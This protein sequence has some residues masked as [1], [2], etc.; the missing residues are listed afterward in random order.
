MGVALFS[1]CVNL[2]ILTIIP[3]YMMQ[4]YDRVLITSSID[5]LLTLSAMV[6]VGLATF[7]LL[8]AVRNRILA[9]VGAWFE[10]ELGSP[11][12]GGAIAEARRAG[13]ASRRSGCTHPPRCRAGSAWWAPVALFGCA[14]LN[15]LATRKRLTEASSASVRARAERRRRRHPQRGRHHRHE[16]FPRHRARVSEREELIN[17]SF[18]PLLDPLLGPLPHSSASIVRT[19]SS[20]G[21]GA[22]AVPGNG[23]GSSTCSAQ[24]VNASVNSSSSCAR[25]N[26]INV[27]SSAGNRARSRFVSSAISADTRLLNGR[28]GARSGG[29]SAGGAAGMMARSNVARRWSTLAKAI[30]TARSRESNQLLPVQPS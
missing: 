12:L 15:D 9:R 18:E 10:R 16:L 3:M 6:A 30:S 23:L 11:I 21:S 25:N 1:A 27:S 20:L 17:F 14:A 22:E 29:Y 19:S 5:A 4:V 26:S 28:A 7:G 13:A 2:L 8:D 24:A